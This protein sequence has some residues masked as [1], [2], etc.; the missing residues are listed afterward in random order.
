[1]GN[2]DIFDAIADKYES[3][4]RIEITEIISK[5]I[6][7]YIVDGKAKN[8]IDFGCGTGLI[9]MSLINDFQ[10]MI[11]LDTS[12]NMLEKIKQKIADFNIRNADTLCFDFETAFRADI[13]ADYI[14]VVQVLL[15]IENVE[16]VLS[17]LYELLNPEGHLLIVDFNKNE[18]VISDKVH[19]GFDLEML[20]ELMTK[21]GFK[22]IESKTFYS[23]EKIFMNQDA[24]LFI[25]DSKK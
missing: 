19:N 9:G 8:A 11:F 23:G 10:S 12:Q 16:L 22:E 24:S 7:E 2:T 5:V 18:E 20:I 4:E 21:I 3:C 17:R 1:M 25:L 13:P 15:H 6:R 14:F